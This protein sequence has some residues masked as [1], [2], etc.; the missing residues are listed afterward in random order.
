M[1][2]RA[3][4]DA[5]AQGMRRFLQI[6]EARF[7][8][9]AMTFRVIRLGAVWRTRLERALKSTGLSV[10]G[11]RPM[12]YLMMM[13][14]GTSQRALAA[15]MDTDTSALVR[16]LDLLEASGLVER[17]PDA[18]DRRTNRLFITP[19]GQRKC[20]QFHRIAARLERD[21]TMGLDPDAAPALVRV[22]DRILLNAERRTHDGAGAEA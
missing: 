4:D 3:E 17:R 22:M 13:P 5:E 16:V 1:D 19:A 7:R 9:V 6:D 18:A 15:A 11:F 20:R 10:A 12:A 14:D 21:L 2:R 8:D